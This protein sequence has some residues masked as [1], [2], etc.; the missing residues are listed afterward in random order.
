VQRQTSTRSEACRLPSLKCSRLRLTSSCCH[1]GG[2]SLA[3]PFVKGQ[4]AYAKFMADLSFSVTPLRRDRCSSAACHPSPCLVVMTAVHFDQLGIPRPSLSSIF[5]NVQRCSLCSLFLHAQR[6]FGHSDSINS[7]MN[8]V[9]L[10]II[11]DRDDVVMIALARRTLW[12][13]PGMTALAVCALTSI[14]QGTD[15]LAGQ[16]PAHAACSPH[17]KSPVSLRTSHLQFISMAF[18]TSTQTPAEGASA[19]TRELALAYSLQ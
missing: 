9:F 1:N 5:P 16:H 14:S 4:S 19:V 7:A 11:H 18:E 12:Q 10:A 15:C 13:V 6:W 17:I 2:Q 3:A 8:C